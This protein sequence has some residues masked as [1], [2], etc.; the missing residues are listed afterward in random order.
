MLRMVFHDS[1]A[2]LFN[3]KG[4]RGAKKKLRGRRISKVMIGKFK[5]FF[6]MMHFFDL[7]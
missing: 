4:Q 6:Y 2:V 1:L 5:N 3:W 7:I